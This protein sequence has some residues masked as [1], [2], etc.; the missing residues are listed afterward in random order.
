MP[1]RHACPRPRPPLNAQ[2][3]CAFALPLP[4]QGVELRICIHI[5][6][7]PCGPKHC[8]CRGIQQHEVSRREILPQ[9]LGTLH[10]GGGGSVEF[11]HR[12]S[13]QRRIGQHPGSMDNAGH[14]R[15]LRLLQ[16]A[17]ERLHLLCRR[18]I[19]LPGNDLCCGID[20]TCRLHLPGQ[21][22]HM[23]C[24]LC[25]Q[26]LKCHF[27]QCTMATT[28]DIGAIGLHRE[29]WRI[30][31]ACRHQTGNRSL[32]RLP[33]IIL[34]RCP[35][36]AGLYELQNVFARALQAAQVERRIFQPDTAHQGQDGCRC[37]RVGRYQYRNRG[38]QLTCIKPLQEAQ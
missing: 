7:L 33:A 30:G 1:H 32:S 35:D 3:P 38:A 4:G 11:F 13:G 34:A 17:R 23:R 20:L 18:H 10:L 14:R 8:C 29:R 31:R 22:H 37:D 21:Q 27:A 9:I 12:L 2:H 5:A 26:I 28:D 15:P 6:A 19:T 25:Q 24:A 36:I 16:P